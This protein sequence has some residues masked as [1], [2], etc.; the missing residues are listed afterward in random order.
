M[1]LT[2]SLPPISIPQGAEPLSPASLLRFGGQSL[3]LEESREYGLA[4]QQELKDRAAKTDAFVAMANS[5]DGDF[6]KF[7]DAVKALGAMPEGYCF[8]ST[9]RIG[10]DSKTHEPECA[11]I[12]ALIKDN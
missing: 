12:R 9:N 7:V 2:A 4:L 6:A 8:C 3:D 10:D 11:D 1:T 5:M